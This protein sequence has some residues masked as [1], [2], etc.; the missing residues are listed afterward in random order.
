MGNDRAQRREILV[1]DVDEVGTKATDDVTVGLEVE[2]IA[3][4]RLVDR[5]AQKRHSF[6][7]EQSLKQAA[8]TQERH[9]VTAQLEFACQTHRI[10]ACASQR[11]I[12]GYE[13]NTLHACAFASTP[14][15][16]WRIKDE[17]ANNCSYEPQSM[18][19][20]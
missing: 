5:R 20:P 9:L 4:K 2:H 19:L 13:E 10:E 16:N 18:M 7:F 1:L 11:E 14:L 15:S 6:V 8:G 3:P 12:T 17:R